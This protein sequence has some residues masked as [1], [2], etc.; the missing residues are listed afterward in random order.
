MAKRSL[1]DKQIDQLKKG[2]YA[3][4][5]LLGL[6]VRVTNTNRLFY[7]AARDLNRKQ[8]WQRI[9]DR[10]T[11][12]V[13]EAVEKAPLFL[14][15]IKEG[16]ADVADAGDGPPTFKKIAEQWFENHVKDAERTLRSADYIRGNLDNHL[17]PALGAREFET[18]HRGD[19]VSMLDKIKKNTGATAADK[20]LNITQRIC[21][22]YAVR[23]PKYATPVVRGMRVIS[24]KERARDRILTDDELRAIWKT[25]EANGQF[26]AFIRLLLLT[27]QRREKVAAMKWSEIE[28]G[29]WTIPADAR[30]KGNAEKI[31]LPPGGAGHPG[32]APARRW[33]PLRLRRGTQQDRGGGQEARADSLL[34]LQQDEE[35]CD[36]TV[37]PASLT[38]GST[39]CAG[40]LG[41][42]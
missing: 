41:R 18:I 34:R 37:R 6:Y 21:N 19:I 30:E 8:V 13:A 15:A 33:Q 10:T 1:N 3:V 24:T 29:V 32:R 11:M 28:D 14:K 38:G 23:H 17:I 2:T 16:N 42:C 26:G 4:P 35:G 12:S 36:S 20:C 22:W 25:A 39:T 27:G 31:K 5:Q 9:G 7:V 40:P